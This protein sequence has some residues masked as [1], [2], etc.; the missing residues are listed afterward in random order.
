MSCPQVILNNYEEA[1]SACL[2]AKLLIMTDDADGLIASAKEHLPVEQL[3][4]IRGSPHPFFVEF[5]KDGVTKGHTLVELCKHLGVDRERVVAFGDGDN[6]QEMLHFA[7]LGCAMKNAKD[8]AKS[9]ANCVIEVSS[10]SI[11][12]ISSY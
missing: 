5:L 11:I 3:T 4:I 12:S 2:S 1:F 7:G 9:Q 6:D 8:A 10:L